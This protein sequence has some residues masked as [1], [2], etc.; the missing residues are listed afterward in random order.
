MPRSRG[1]ER[2]HHYGRERQ[3]FIARW[4]L[5]AE[6]ADVGLW[7]FDVA[8]R[9]IVADARCKALFGLSPDA[10]TSSDLV[11]EIIHP[12]DRAHVDVAFR[13]ALDPHGTGEYRAE[14]RVVGAADGQLRWVV[15]RGR[16][17]ERDAAGAPRRMMGTLIDIGDRKRIERERELFVA[18]IGHD[19]R[20]PL[21]TIKTLAERA[22]RAGRDDDG[23][24]ARIA[25]AADRM[26]RMLD[27]LVDFSRSQLGEL[28]LDRREID[29]REVFSEVAAEIGH[30]HP[31]VKLNV[32]SEGATTGLWDRARLTR[33]AQNL[34]SNAVT[35]GDTSQPITVELRGETEVVTFGVRNRGSPIDR[36]VLPTLFEP[37]RRAR[38][39][40]QGLGLGLYIVR[41]VIEAHGGAIEVHSDATTGTIFSALLP[42]RP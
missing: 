11:R 37:F 30:A 1:V 39:G 3:R 20:N 31:G 6:A 2:G 42:R 36:A 26:A 16:V 17:T 28:P 7:D 34:L 25:S 5:A 22:V 33:V 13:A 24:T 9:E 14:Y 38:D 32:L 4:Q 15:A 10:N 40:G 41:T 21:A 12:D 8:T 23:A 29:L 19:L 35:H 27:E 18:A